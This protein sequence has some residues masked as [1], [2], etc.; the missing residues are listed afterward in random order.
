MCLCSQRA[1]TQALSK[2]LTQRQTCTRTHLPTG[3]LVHLRV[4]TYVQL[5]PLIYTQC[6]V[7]LHLFLL[8]SLL[9]TNECQM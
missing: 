7:F 8:P 5:Y 6:A 4:Y 1:G 3:T 2:S 9:S